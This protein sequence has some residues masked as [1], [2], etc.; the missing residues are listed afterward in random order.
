MLR[1]TGLLIVLTASWQPLP[2]GASAGSTQETVGVRQL[3]VQNKY[4]NLPVKN[5]AAKRQM[6]M[7]VDGQ[8]VREFT[9][10]LADGTP[11]FWV[12]LDVSLFQGKTATLRVEPPARLE[13]VQPSDRIEGAGDLYREKHRPQFHFS[14][15]R[16]W[17]NDSN[18]LVFYK[19]EY[20]LYYQH[21]PYGWS[22]GNMHWGHAV[23]TDLVHWTE[24]P[25]ALYPQKFGDWCYSGS[26]VVDSNN[27]AGFK[28]G[29][30][31]VIVAAYTSTGR[32]ECLAYSN[33]RGRTFT[34]YPG[35]PVVTHK[36]R[37]PKVFWYGPGR[38]WAM[39]V[40][41]ERDKSRGISFYSSTNLKDWQFGSRIDGFYECPELFELAVDG[42]RDNR[43]WIVHAADGDYVIG[44][45]DGK[46]FT[47]ESAKLRW[48]YGNCFYASQT[49]NGLPPEDGRRI[50][51]AW[52]RIPTPGMPFNQCMLFPC[53]LTL[54]T[55][56]EGTR[57]FAAPVREIATLHEQTQRW[58]DEVLT[59]DS[60]PLAGIRGD[61]FH[62]QG[63]FE[64]SRARSLQLVI[65]GVPITYDA[66]KQELSCQGKTA[67]L[68]PADGTIALEVLVDRTSLEIFG[69]RGRVYMP[70]GVIPADGDQCLRLLA[71][72]GT[73]R[74]RSLEVH[75]LR[76]AW[77]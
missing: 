47:P 40:Y 45:F 39:A 29:V 77:R 25:M 10:E 36:G 64:I 22:W 76:S 3:V 48:S 53:E 5:G 62:I 61:L 66:T 26:A 52:G 54:R 58:T 37:D 41:D 9:I 71:E 17:N 28:T 34:D 55:T 18:G 16:G 32:G 24:L 57:M 1:V 72:G 13:A 35:N 11:D 44:R 67:P 15:R 59:P 7:V 70:I 75:Q 4:L 65:P 31:D 74:I 69:N 6:S 14:S 19:G 46:T 73:A 68:K 12:F 23:S 60:N 30:E 8:T 63:Q 33:D 43:K 42:D 51:I 2:A 20:H 27:T 49:F 50:Q 56:E 38:H 21:N